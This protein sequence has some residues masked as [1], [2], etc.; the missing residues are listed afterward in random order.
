MLFDT[1][2]SDTERTTLAA[3][4]AAAARG[5]PLARPPGDVGDPAANPVH[6]TPSGRANQPRAAEQ[7]APPSAAACTAGRKTDGPLYGA[8]ALGGGGRPE[9]P[10][11]DPAARLPQPS[12]FNAIHTE[13][14]P[15]TAVLST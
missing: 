3:T 14:C 15:V 5:P 10:E 12:G 7:S 2:E 1:I 6:P 11:A 9:P 8:A 4:M 13:T